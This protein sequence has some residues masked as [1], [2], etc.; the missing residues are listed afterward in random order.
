MS[1]AS[2]E[3]EDDDRPS[4]RQRK[5][6]AGWLIAAG[7]SDAAAAG[8][9][10]GSLLLADEDAGVAGWIQRLD[11]HLHQTGIASGAALA[12]LAASD[13]PAA[14]VAST[15]NEGAAPVAAAPGDSRVPLL[16]PTLPREMKRQPL[17]RLPAV[18]RGGAWILSARHA[19][20]HRV[21]PR[22]SRT[23]WSWRDPTPTA[24]A[25][26]H[27]GPIGRRAE[28]RGFG[29][30]GVPCTLERPRGQ[31]KVAAQ[32]AGA[33]RLRRGRCRVVHHRAARR[34]ASRVGAA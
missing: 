33:P 18:L 9:L 28:S 20:P 25:R 16:P 2:P 15:S 22:L 8:K 27:R 6:L 24:G 30:A 29:S 17:G 7:L 11:A 32:P 14:E 1:D 5:R 4:P 3:A 21:G 23:L 34:I 26:P 19:L 31:R 12:R 13:D 10:A